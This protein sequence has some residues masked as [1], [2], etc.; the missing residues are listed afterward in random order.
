ML[1]EGLP[2]LRAT[3]NKY[4][5]AMGLNFR[6]D[7]ARCE[8]DYAAAVIA[9]DESIALLRA[10]DAGR[11]LASALHNQGHAV[12]Q[13]GDVARARAHFEES[14]ALQQALENKPGMA[15]CLLGFAA[16][17]IAQELPAAAARLLAAAAAIGGRAVTKEWAATRLTYER[18]LARVTAALPENIL[19]D[20]QIVGQT[21]SLEKAVSD[22]LATARK[23][24]AAE[25]ARKKLDALT[26]RER[27]VALLVA[28]AKSND[29]I[30]E[31]L[32]LS[33]R[34]VETHVSHILSKL[35]FASRTQIVRW[36]L[37]S[38]LV[39]SGE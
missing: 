3:G 17:A 14:M 36:A 39:P 30:A 16:L 24:A 15:E 28:Q 8:E 1:D 2:L 7:L 34:T 13:L 21:L 29:E 37:E 27:E 26:P 9:Y 5:I 19:L 32:V 22:A 18:L 10:I 11:D 20:E 31:E 4:R 12:L 6:G 38:G 25:A 23:G 33:K 35:G